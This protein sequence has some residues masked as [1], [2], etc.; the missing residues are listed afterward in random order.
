MPLPENQYTLVYN[1]EVEDFHTYYVADS[2]VLVHNICKNPNGYKTGDIDAYNN[3]SPQVNRAVGHKNKKSDGYVQAHHII[4]DEWAKQSGIKGYTSGKAPTILLKSVKGSAH[5]KI[6]GLQKSRRFDVG[7]ATTLR[8]E[9]YFSYDSMIKSGI[10]VKQAK[11]AIKKSYKY[12]DS[13]RDKYP[14]QNQNIFN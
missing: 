1:L 10:P 5:A 7:Y 3:L 14:K 8:S 12:F 2:Y 9:F 6:S 11:N 4:Q 13:L